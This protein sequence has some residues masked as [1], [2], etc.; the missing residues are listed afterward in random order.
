MTFVI[1]SLGMLAL[2]PVHPSLTSGDCGRVSLQALNWLSFQVGA[3]S[4][5]AEE[6]LEVIRVSASKSSPMMEAAKFVSR[7][8]FKV[9]PPLPPSLPPSLPFFMSPSVCVYVCSAFHTLML[10]S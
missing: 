8:F 3:E 7:M 9:S 6:V 1:T 2:S 10:A 5:Q 4:S